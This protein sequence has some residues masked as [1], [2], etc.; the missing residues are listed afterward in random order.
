LRSVAASSAA[1]PAHTLPP[2][3]LLG[4]ALWWSGRAAEATAVLDTATREAAGL[5]AQ[6]DLRARLPRR[7]RF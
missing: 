6:A 5:D 3:L 2:R 7:D 1:G 4:A